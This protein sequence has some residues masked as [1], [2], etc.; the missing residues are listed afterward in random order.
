MGL[1]S[2]TERYGAV[3]VSVTWLTAVLIIVLIA[4]GFRA[5]GCLF[6]AILAA[7]C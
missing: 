5:A 4:S 3:V 1:K 6:E 7:K 2:T